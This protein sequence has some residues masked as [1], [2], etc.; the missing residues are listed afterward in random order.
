MTQYLEQN[1]D[2]F[3]EDL[4]AVLRIPSVSAQPGHRDDMKRCARHIADELK[5]IG[6]TRAEVHETKGHPIVYAEW[7]GAPGKPTALVYGHY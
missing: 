3:V 6:M 4:K 5:H 7:L 1:R 2:K